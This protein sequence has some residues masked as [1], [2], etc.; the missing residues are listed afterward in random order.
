VDTDVTVI[1][2]RSLGVLEAH[3]GGTT[4]LVVADLG[5]L[6]RARSNVTAGGTI[7]HAIDDVHVGL[8]GGGEM[9]LANGEPLFLLAAGELGGRGELSLNAFALC[10]ISMLLL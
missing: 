8:L 5:A 9:Q 10:A 2:L 3:G 1:I 7:G 6:G 4:A